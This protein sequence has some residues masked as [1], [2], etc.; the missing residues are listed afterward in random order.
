MARW[1]QYELWVQSGEN[2]WDMVGVFPD[3]ELPAILARARNSRA[4]LIE[5]LYDDSKLL[6]QEVI[7]EIGVAR[8][9][10]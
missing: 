10:K 1:K 2:K 7:A 4:P 3:P 6:A 5:V 8:E 9:T